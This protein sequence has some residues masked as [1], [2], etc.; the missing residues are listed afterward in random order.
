MLDAYLCDVWRI[1]SASLWNSDAS[2]S[3]EMACHSGIP[4]IEESH[5]KLLE[6]LYVARHDGEIVLKS[7]R[8]DHS[9]GHIQWPSG[10]LPSPSS[11][12][13]RSA[14]VCVTGRMR[15]WNQD[16]TFS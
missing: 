13:H 12:P 9:V 7:C 8:G 2:G 11:V 15:F 16:G 4:R 6:I 10:K 1:L 5:A 3:D 14:I